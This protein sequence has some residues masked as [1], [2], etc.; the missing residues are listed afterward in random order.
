MHDSDFK[1]IKRLAESENWITTDKKG[2]L[3]DRA[4]EARTDYVSKVLS[5]YKY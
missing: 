1:A 5:F 4:V 2:T 3:L